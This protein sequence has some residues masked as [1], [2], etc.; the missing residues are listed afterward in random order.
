MVKN[1]NSIVQQIK[2]VV[3]TTGAIAVGMVMAGA[4]ILLC[5]SIVFIPVGSLLIIGS[6]Y[7]LYRVITRRI[8][9]N[10]AWADRDKPL[11]EDEERSKPWL[12][13]D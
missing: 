12:E 1:P 11:F 13:Q 9:D 4:G 7:L 2:L 8:K 10:L 5:M 6:G 3:K